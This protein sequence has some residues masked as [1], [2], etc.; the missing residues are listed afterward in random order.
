MKSH[1]TF[2]MVCAE[3]TEFHAPVFFLHDD[4]CS[5]PSRRDRFDGDEGTRG[6]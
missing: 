6:H 5:Q 3:Q 4:P 2:W 1:I